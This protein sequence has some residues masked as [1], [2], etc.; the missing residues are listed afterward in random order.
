MHIRPDIAAESSMPRPDATD[1]GVPVVAEQRLVERVPIARVPQAEAPSKAPVA[2]PS[3]P[4]QPRPRTPIMYTVIGAFEDRKAAQR[5]V[6]QLLLRGFARES[7]DLQ[8][9][10]D[11]LDPTASTTST[12]V[13]RDV[14]L[15]RNQDDGFLAGVRHFFASLF[16]ADEERQVGI[17]SEAVRRGST[18]VVVDARDQAEA[19]RAAAAMRE[20]GGTIDLDERSAAWR[21]EGSDAAKPHAAT[22]GT[23]GAMAA[24]ALADEER[25]APTAQRNHE[26]S[27]DALTDAERRRLAGSAADEDLRPVAQQEVK[28]GER[29]VEQGGVRVLR[30]VTETPVS[31]LV[32]QREE[33]ART[34]EPVVEKVARVVEDKLRRTDVEIDRM[35]RKADEELGR[36]T[37]DEYNAEDEPMRSSDATPRTGERGRAPTPSETRRKT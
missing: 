8:A 28:I 11:T 30:R 4:T 16:G 33:R 22:G 24:Q 37:G 13:D 19:D 35:A 26:R 9:R 7:I 6:D 1:I 17:Y 32:R 20:M 23:A 27:N 2:G 18:L 29:A 3:S 34:E 10:P 31:E 36:A 15:R 12:A 25:I 14:D 21:A 5:T